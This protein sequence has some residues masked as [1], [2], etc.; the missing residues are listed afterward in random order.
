M[1]KMKADEEAKY[2]QA[3]GSGAV[4]GSPGSGRTSRSTDLHSSG[5]I[6]VYLLHLRMSSP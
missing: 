6:C 3:T 4:G 1:K 2:I 5:F